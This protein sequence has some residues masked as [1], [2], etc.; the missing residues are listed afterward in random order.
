MMKNLS[1]M[2]SDEIILC[3]AKGDCIEARGE[4]A[5]ILTLG[6]SVLFLGIAF[7]YIFKKR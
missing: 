7:Y 6:A 2:P 5:R 3:D 1:Y 4:N